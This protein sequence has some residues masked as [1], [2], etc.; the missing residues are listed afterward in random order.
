MRAGCYTAIITPF[1]STS[2][3]Y[4]GLEQLVR[5]QI[6]NG[7]TGILA[8]GTTGES[9]TLNWDEHNRVIGEVAKNSKTQLCL[10]R[11][12]RQQQYR[13]NHFGD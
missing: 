7:I 9:P 10:H 6:K 3:D 8:V 2:V 11:R 12:N 13:R 5:F 1:T 4:E